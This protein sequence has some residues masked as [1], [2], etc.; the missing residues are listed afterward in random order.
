MRAPWLL[1]GMIVVGSL[2][3]D[4]ALQQVLQDLGQGDQPGAAGTGGTLGLDG[5]AGNMGGTPDGAAGGAG[6]G[7]GPG[8]ACGTLTLGTSIALAPAAAGQGY[9]RCDTL[10][11]E[12]GWQLTLSPAGDRLAARTG[13]GT[14]RLLATDPW[15]EIAEL[16]SPLGQI[17]AVAF[18]PDGATLAT[19]SAEMGE[20]TLFGAA[21]GTV[22]RSF[23]GPAASGIDTSAAALA[24]SSD[25]RRLATS[26]GTVIDLAAGTTTSW[27]TGAAET[28]TLAVNPENL[29][30]SVA[31]GSIPLVRF[32]AGDAQ[33]FLETDYQVGNSPT[34]TRLELRAPGTGTQ[35]VLYD[36]YSRG[37]LGYAVSPDGR[38]VARGTT[39]EAAAQGFAA[40]LTVFDAT[41]G[42]Q[43]AFDPS[44]TGA[45]DGF[46]DDGSELFTA[47]GTTISVA[48]S[49]DLHSI[50]QFA[51]PAGVTF[52]GISPA[53]NFVGSTAGATSWWSP[54]TGQIVQT[55]GYALAA[56][57][58]SGDGRFG[59]GTGDPSALFHFWREA[60]ATQLCAPSADASTAPPLASLGTAGP[61]GE[62]QAATSADGA[63]T[64]TCAFVIHDHA[65]NYDALGVTAAATGALLRQFGATAGTEPIAVSTPAGDRLFTP[66]G[67]DVAVWCR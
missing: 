51:V 47:T 27:Q 11:P 36:F 67:S 32:T 58:W 5:G 66:Q 48:G 17:D 64:I 40:G 14:V 31:G 22:Q 30:F 56:A 24:F 42:A 20:V 54:T 25:G 35:I 44:F 53:G 19:L 10:G 18:S 62:N 63:L 2:G 34:S 61:A 4:R 1:S 28:F 50:H 12:T 16:G 57:I 15:R 46:S 21:D 7:G 23:A 26:L 3:C 29:G 45:V 13:A 52:L 41:T 37:L 55:S 60:D 49:A 33:L 8:V 9:V 59:A 43:L 6:Q 65:T 39:A 38:Y